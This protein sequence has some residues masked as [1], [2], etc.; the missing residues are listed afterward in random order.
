MSAKDSFKTFQA[1]SH[2]TCCHIRQAT[3]M[4]DFVPEF[5]LSLL[6]KSPDGADQ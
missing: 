6:Y 1:P 2:P 4:A 3:S 5:L